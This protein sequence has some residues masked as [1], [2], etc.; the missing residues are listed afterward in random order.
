MIIHVSTKSADY[1]AGDTLG[2]ISTSSGIDPV[3]ENKLI[4]NSLN[5]VYTPDA[6]FVY[7][8]LISDAR[9]QKQ[10]ITSERVII[11]T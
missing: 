3:V 5:F 7:K 9:I 6:R 2:E 10:D 4:D 11:R 8:R 1:W